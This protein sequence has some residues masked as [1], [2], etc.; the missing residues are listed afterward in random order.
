MDDKKTS[1]KLL[2]PDIEK[3]IDS[4]EQRI[5]DAREDQDDYE[6]KQFGIPAE[7]TPA[8]K[9][10]KRIAGEFLA[11]VVSGGLLG[12]LIDKFFETGPWAMMFFIIIGFI[13]A[14]YR[15]DA[16]TKKMNK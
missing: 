9:M 15:A 11:T 14:V 12:L 5:Q 16:I 6:E 13:G 3:K 8:E 2:D 4:L 10:G 1:P 7:D